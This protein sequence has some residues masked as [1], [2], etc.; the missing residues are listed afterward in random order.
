MSEVY[1]VVYR[2]APTAS[3][4]TL[5]AGKLPNGQIVVPLRDLGR[6]LD[7][8]DMTINRA[9]ARVAQVYDTRDV[10]PGAQSRR[11]RAVSLVDVAE[12]R[13]H[14]AEWRASGRAQIVKVS[15]PEGVLRQVELP[16]TQ[17]GDR[18]VSGHVPAMVR[19]EE[20]R[21]RLRDVAALCGVPLRNAQHRLRVALAPCRT[22]VA[23]APP[24][25][26]ALHTHA[27]DMLW[28][29]TAAT[30]GAPTTTWPLSLA[31]LLVRAISVARRPGRP[32]AGDSHPGL[33]ALSTGD[34]A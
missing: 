26:W 12:I 20:L 8:W 28:A 25:Y 5:R 13:R 34:D 30:G 31:P 14:V 9:A 33:T 3:G 29:S 32:A 11:M 10:S 24:A 19:G 22:H 1:P 6:A 16:P 21:I 23:G 7:L 27:A 15:P 4:H 18:V 17:L 2:A